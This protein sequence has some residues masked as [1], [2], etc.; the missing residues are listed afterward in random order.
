M[1]LIFSGS[2]LY[3]G[4]NLA[5][6][7]APSST[8]KNILRGVKVEVRDHRVRFTATDLEVLI[9]CLMPV[10]ECT[11]DG[12]I[13][14][15]AVRVNNILREWASNDEVTM[16]VEGS[17]CTLKSRGGRFKIAGEDA[18]QFPDITVAEMKDFVEIDGS[19]IGDMAGKVVHAVSKVKTKS[20]LSGV[21]VR[22]SGDDIVMVAT[23]GNRMSFI[24]RK[25]QNP[26]GSPV[27]GVVSVK[28]LMFLQRFV[29]EC[30]GP[31]RVGVGES[32]VY[33]AGER[34][35][36]MSQLLDGPYPRYEDM[37]PEGND[38]IVEVNKDELLS[39][40]RMASFMTNE[41][42]QIV[43]FIIK[44]GKLMVTAGASDVGEAEMEIAAGYE[45]PDFV[46]NF[47]PEYVA[48]AIKVSDSDT[49]VM[50]FSG[51]EGAVVF[52]TGCEQMD[53]IMPIE[54]M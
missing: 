42:Y 23:D 37:V 43:K 27:E 16:Q 8:V 21:L 25:V 6:G 36:L 28:C 53:V 39:V 47:N 33:F 50:K 52:K 24:K 2:D 9:K 34:G 45:G 38:R 22:I 12:S 54:P 5:A 51:G 13:V 31:L 11:E 46:I 41:G 10:K 18:V 44:S 49:V 35:E 48:D 14:L 26:V 4:F 29:S 15:P 19:V 17:S 3:T 32:R 7:V 40:V 20:V 30:K 1:N